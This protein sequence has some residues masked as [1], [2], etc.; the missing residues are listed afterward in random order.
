MRRRARSLVSWLARRLGASE[1]EVAILL[2]AIALG[3]L[4][5]WGFVLANHVYSLGGDEVE[6]DIEARFLAHGHWWWSTT[7]YG[8]AHAS[9]WKAPG[10][11]LVLGLLYKAVGS[12]P[13]RA[14]MIQ[15]T[16]GIATITLTWLLA[17]RLFTP[18]AASVAA[19][20]MAVYPFAWLWEVSLYSESIA[21]PLG[22][23]FL[24]LVLERPAPTVRRAAAIGVLL[25]VSLLVRPSALMLIPM[26][27]VAWVLAAGL[28]RGVA[29][30]AVAVLVAALCV[31]PWT[32]RNS[33][34]GD[35][36][37][38]PISA[39]DAAAYGTFNDDAAHD[40]KQPWNWRP[41]THRDLDVY[42]PTLA[43]AELAKQRR[44]E[45]DLRAEL[46]RRARAYIRA[47]PESVPKAFFWNGV[48]RLWDLRRPAYVIDE[49]RQAHG[50]TVM[51]A[52]GLLL[53]W[54][55]LA[56]ALFALWRVRRRRR[57]VWPLLVLAL[58]ASVVYT[59][60]SGTRYR[61]PFEPLVVILAASWAGRRSAGAPSG[62]AAA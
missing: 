33:R 38:V 18:R 62:P 58:A 23:C 39:Q 31:A 55:M 7:P 20:V 24:L 25:G 59:S 47:H 21:T 16:I 44:S 46:M 52:A 48:T 40:P 35:G 22:L 27:A 9:F 4:V 12:N 26:L 28:R 61:A 57:L 32:Y 53:Y 17:R 50:S 11:P 56:L 19:I 29:T 49:A 42:D 41:F 43:P 37:F 34:V 15:A 8:D 54:P 3:M 2:G 51:T 36:A 13:F 45:A 6:Y 1:R 10:Y 5:R 60:D 30:T 14:E